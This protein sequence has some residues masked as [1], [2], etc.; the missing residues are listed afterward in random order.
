MYVASE[1]ATDIP[2]GKKNDLTIYLSGSACGDL[3]VP[4]A[5]VAN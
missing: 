1:S 3:L 5:R 4:K 2:M